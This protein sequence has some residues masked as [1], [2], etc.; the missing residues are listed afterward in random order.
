MDVFG[1]GGGTVE[2]DETFIGRDFGKKPKGEKK[3][4]GFH[5]KNKV[6]SLIDRTTGRARSMVVDDLNVKTL[7]PLLKANIAPDA[8]LMTDEANHYYQMRHHFAGHGTTQHGRG[9]VCVA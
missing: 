9:E 7:L 2:A 4:R 6:L 1:S 8:I 3:G 5:H